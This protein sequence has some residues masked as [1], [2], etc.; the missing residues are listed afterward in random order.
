M[1][2]LEAIKTRRSVRRFADK[3][4]EETKLKK[5]LEAVQQSPSWANLQCWRLIVAKD[6][7]VREKLSELSYVESFLHLW[8][9]KQIHQEKAL[10]RRLLQL[11]RVLTLHSQESSGVR[12]IT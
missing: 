1:E 6:K 5:I 9:T 2:L 8:A 12:I 11:L 3:P 7:K 10:Q 4:V